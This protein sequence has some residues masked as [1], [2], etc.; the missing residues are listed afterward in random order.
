MMSH[1]STAAGRRPVEAAFHR[2]R[3]ILSIAAAACA[4]ST[5]VYAQGFKVADTN[6]QVHGF[7]QQG[8]IFS[9]GNN[10]LTMDTTGGSGEMTDGGINASSQ[11]NKKLR[12]GMQLYARNIGQLGNGHPQL[13]WAFADYRFNQLIGVRGGKVK[14]ALGLYNDTQDMEF[15]HTW[16]LLPQSVYAL[17]LRSV[18]IAHVGAD[19]YG[20][21]SG[22]RAGSLNYTVYAGLIQ[23][24]PRGGYR[25]GIEDSGFKFKDGMHR[26]GYGLDLRW[27]APVD[28]LQMG[29][30]QVS[31]PGTAD[32]T[33]TGVP[34]PLVLGLTS[35]RTN[36][37][38]GDY[39]K[40]AWHVSGEWRRVLVVAKLTP[41]IIPVTNV[42]TVAWYASA[43]YRIAK[44]LEVG[45]YYSHF[46]QNTNLDATLANNHINGPA[47]TARIDLNRFVAVKVEGQF[48]DGF[49]SSYASRG[50]YLR[51]NVTGIDNVNGMKNSTNMLVLRTSFSF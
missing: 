48:M 16:A 44:P 3:S 35:F 7:V 28:G 47:V 23:D 6:V 1:K 32:V 18:N 41:A 20:A 2:M 43:A 10:F 45:A 51:N 46:V 15:L 39:Q 25:Y 22:K 11:I 8:Y 27:T 33:R 36:A 12:V 29:Y 17:D 21:L 26:H 13:D 40:R 14:S 9:N 50:F 24:D 42:P 19:V 4:V 5:T 31:M 34:F 37:V 30:S 49:G 38:Y